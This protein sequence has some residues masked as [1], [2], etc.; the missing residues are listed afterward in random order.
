MVKRKITKSKSNGLQNTI[1]KTNDRVTRTPL[2]SLGE[3]MCSGRASSSC[4]PSDTR[5]VTVRRHE[6]HLIWKPYWI[7]VYMYVDKNK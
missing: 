1:L 3:P 6:H 7:P 4:S 2:K 5:C